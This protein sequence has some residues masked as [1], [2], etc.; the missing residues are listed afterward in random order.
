[1]VTIALSC[2]GRRAATCRP[3]KPPQDM[4]IMPALPGTRLLPSHSII[5]SASS[6]SRLTYS[7]STRPS[8][9]PMPAMSTRARHIHGRQTRYASPHRRGGC[10]RGGDRGCIRG[11]GNRVFLGVLRQER[12]AASLRPSP[13]G[14][15][16]SSIFSAA[17]SRAVSW[18]RSG[19]S[20]G[21]IGFR[22]ADLQRAPNS[23]AP[24]L[25]FAPS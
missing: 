12:R 25:P 17:E 2:G 8:E 7:S 24:R 3:L 18:S 4:P 5:S 16:A 9:S 20:S 10:R 19:M 1:M 21:R 23:I 15:Q 13:I 11:S 6:C 22:G 14:I